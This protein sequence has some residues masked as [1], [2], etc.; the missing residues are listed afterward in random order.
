[1]INSFI[2]FAEMAKSSWSYFIASFQ[3]AG[4]YYIAVAI[5]AYQIIVL[6]TYS[7]DLQ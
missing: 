7:I 1:M 4:N 3:T 6:Y 5:H 2:L